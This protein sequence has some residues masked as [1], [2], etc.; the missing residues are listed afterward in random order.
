MYLQSRPHSLIRFSPKMNTEAPLNI[1]SLGSHGPDDSFRHLQSYD[2]FFDD[3][4]FVG[5]S[6][7]GI[8]AMPA[9]RELVADGKK[10]DWY[11][12]PST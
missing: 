3:I 4:L 2:S 9:C 8:W 12:F 10:S 6:I 5:M 7:L 1:I 11:A